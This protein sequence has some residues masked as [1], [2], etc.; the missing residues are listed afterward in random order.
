MENTNIRELRNWAEVIFGYTLSGLRDSSVSSL[1]TK[2]IGCNS[3]HLD[4]NRI[5]V[6]GHMA[7]D[8]PMVSYDANEDYPDSPLDLLHRWSYMRKSHDCYCALKGE[9]LEWQQGQLR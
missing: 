1:P 9:P 2:H 4:V 8:E 3:E 5:Y 7:S 6:K